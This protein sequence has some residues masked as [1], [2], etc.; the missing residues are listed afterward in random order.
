M[1][2]L[3]FPNMCSS[4]G[5]ATFSY[6]PS[7]FDLEIGDYCVAT[8]PQD[9]EDLSLGEVV[10]KFKVPKLKSQKMS[11]KIV[12]KATEEDIKNFSAKRDKER[13]AHKICE[14]KIK[15]RNLP[16]KLVKTEYTYSGNK[17]TF[18]F[19]SEKRV[20]FR[21]L[22]KELAHIFRCRIELRQIGVRDEAK[23]MGGYGMCGRELCCCKFLKKLG[24]LRIKMAREQNMTLTPSKISGICGRL[25][26]CLEYES[27]W[28][29]EQKEKMPKI[30]ST[31]KFG[32]IKGKVE[33]VDY[34]HNT[35]TIRDETGRLIELEVETDE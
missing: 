2:K 30:G 17:V 32:D 25:L 27:E 1:V 14:E 6:D 12:R 29:Q 11:R 34:F 24:K 9:E 20:D 26:C 16:M 28:Y 21:E 33:L 18:Y 3:K 19:A 4:C 10:F 7:E 22:V 31:I 15:D 8:N 13:R 35:V 5:L 23:M